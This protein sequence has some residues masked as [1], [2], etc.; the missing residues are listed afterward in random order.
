MAADRGLLE[1]VRI[2]RFGTERERGKDVGADVEREHLQH[3]DRE[4][5]SPARERPHD[6]R[7]ELGDVV[8]EVIG[9]EAADVGEGRAALLDRGD[10]RG[11]VVVEQHE[12]GGLAGDVGARSP[13]GD[14][15]GG[16]ASAGRVVDAVAGHGDDVTTTDAALARSGACPRA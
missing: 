14:A 12:V 7:R 2:R 15:D 16:L 8:G 3:A 10:D 1:H 6:E 13:H 4:R 5:E 11:E 9:E